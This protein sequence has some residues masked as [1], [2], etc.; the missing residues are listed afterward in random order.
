LSRQGLQGSDDLAAAAWISPRLGG[1][2]GAVTRAVPRGYPAYARICHP[3]EDSSRHLTTWSH[4]AQAT[5]RR[6]HALMQWHALVGCRDPSDATGSLWQGARPRTGN[7]VPEVL[8]HLCDLLADRT[9]TPDDCYFGLWEGWGWIGSDDDSLV[10]RL[11]DSA[12]TTPPP[13]QASARRPSLVRLPG[14][15]YLLLEGPLRAA[16]QVGHWPRPDWFI[17]QSPNIFW[18]SDRAWFV[19]S[20]IDFDSTLVGGSRELIDA[21]LAAPAL[22]SWPVDAD[23]SLAAD[24]DDING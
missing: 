8:G 21:L 7:L 1:S 11:P 22:D 5:N 15:N 4:V 13:P 6:A 12:E 9:T 18:P 3:P 17:P 10:F 14:R 24:A 16:L 20:E 23:D 2:F 19:A